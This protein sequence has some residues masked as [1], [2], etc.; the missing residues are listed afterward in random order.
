MRQQES[1]KLQILSRVVNADKNGKPVEIDML[2]DREHFDPLFA[3][4]NYPEQELLKNIV[5]SLILYIKEIC[6]CVRCLE[7]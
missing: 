3:N 5:T 4:K 6:H 1:L 2:Y 7:K